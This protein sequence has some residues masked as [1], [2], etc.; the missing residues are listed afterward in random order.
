[1]CIRDSTD[2][3]LRYFKSEVMEM[4]H[5]EGLYQIDLLNGSKK[6]V[7]KRQVLTKMNASFAFVTSGMGTTMSLNGLND[8]YILVLENGRRLAGD[9]STTRNT[10]AFRRPSSCPMSLTFPRCAAT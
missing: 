1:M 4:C 7:Y 10:S 8:D 5:R 2:A 6:D 3:A 9:G